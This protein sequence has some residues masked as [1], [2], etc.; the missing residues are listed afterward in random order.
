MSCVTLMIL[1]SGRMLPTMRTP[2]GVV[3]RSV[4]ERFENDL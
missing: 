3:K 2:E 4:W 1:R